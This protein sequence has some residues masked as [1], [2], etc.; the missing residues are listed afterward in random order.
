MPGYEQAADFAADSGADEAERESRICRA[1]RDGDCA[2]A[3][4]PQSRDNEP[5]ATGR[6]CPLPH[7]TEDGDY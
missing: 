3:T 2:S 7:W 1:A 4:C 6:S 5:T